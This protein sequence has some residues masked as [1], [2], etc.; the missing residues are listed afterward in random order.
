MQIQARAMWQGLIDLAWPPQCLICAAPV[1]MQGALC[2]DCWPDLPMIAGL[3]C[4]TCGAPLPGAS[5]HRVAC[6][7]CLRHPPPWH[8]GRAAMLYD[9]HARSL[10]LQLKHNDRADLAVSLGARMAHAAAPLQA[11]GPMLVVPVP[12]HPWRLLQRRYNQ[13]A[14]LAAQVARHLGWPFCPDLL[15]RRR[16]TPSQARKSREE[17]QKNLE[18]ALRLHPRHA[19]RATG[20]KVLLVD[21]VMTTGATLAEATR[22]LQA[23]GAAQVCILTLARVAEA[24]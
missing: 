23:A 22:C 7:D 10:V 1:G 18:A 2:P 3:C 8:R 4:D 12:L 15:Q 14:L 11:E 9:G 5:D 16:A 13:S 19:G 24:V 17:R 6:D 21:D 20:A